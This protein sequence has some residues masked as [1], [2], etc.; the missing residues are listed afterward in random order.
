MTALI[1]ILT[2]LYLGTSASGEQ[3]ASREA[4]IESD[5]VGHVMGGREQGWKFQSV[6]QVKNLTVDDTEESAIKRIVT[7][8][9]R[10]EDPRVP[11]AYEA[12]ARLMY[13]KEGGNWKLDTV[14][15]LS[16]RRLEQPGS[17]NARDRR[18]VY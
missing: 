6:S 13:E 1:G 12:K 2:L 14:G 18:Q 8:T 5:L 4:Q 10:L 3:S 11:G 17:N 15:L 9:M 16:M 7:V